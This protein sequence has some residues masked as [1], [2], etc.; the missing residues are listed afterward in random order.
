MITENTQTLIQELN[1]CLRTQPISKA[2]LFGSLSRGEETKDS[3]VDLLVRYL[4]SD[5]MSL[6]SICRI[7]RDIEHY[8]HRR[9][10]L[11][12]EGQLMPFAVGSAERD[13]ILIYERPY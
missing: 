2:W 1:A 3:D 10:D 6:M 5:E 8:I 4:N 13:K 11:I 7:K 12:E 9:V